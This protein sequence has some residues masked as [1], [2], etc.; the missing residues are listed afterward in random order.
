VQR[1]EWVCASSRIVSCRYISAPYTKYE[2]ILEGRPR[3]NPTLPVSF[4][5]RD[6]SPP[7]S[8][9]P[10]P[11]LNARYLVLFLNH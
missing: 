11:H 6:R 2:G 3:E 5:S 1:G 9:P 8:K 7:S 4:S 10:I